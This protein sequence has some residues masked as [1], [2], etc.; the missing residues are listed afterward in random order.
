MV[1]NSSQTSTMVG[2][3]HTKASVCRHAR[4]V[5]QS[6]WIKRRERE[7]LSFSW[8]RPS[9]HARV[10]SLSGHFY[11]IIRAIPK[12]STEASLEICST[13]RDSSTAAASVYP[14]AGTNPARQ[15]ELCQ[16]QKK[17]DRAKRKRSFLSLFFNQSGDN[18]R[19][20]ASSDTFYLKKKKKSLNL[21][22]RPICKREKTT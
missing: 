10:T 4:T 11:S 9:Q 19:C 20:G 12:P 5:T 14:R 22:R 3:T 18:L 13:V 6:V 1:T 2:F 21:Q 7:T 8:R 16:W 15:A 17:E